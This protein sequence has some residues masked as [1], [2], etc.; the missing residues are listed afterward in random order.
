MGH[1][2]TVASASPPVS[3]LSYLTDFRN[4]ACSLN[5][6][7]LDWE[8]NAQ[9]IIQSI[10]IAK[11]KGAKLR[12]GP[13]L[14]VS[15][16]DCLDH[17][18]EPETFM[19]SWEMLARI[20]DDKD[21]YGCL[22][23]IGA[24]IMHRNLRLNCR[25]LALDGKILLI[26]PKLFL[27]N[28]GNYREMRYF[29]PWPQGRVDDLILPRSMQARQGTTCVPIGDAVLSMADTCIGAET[30]E[31]LFTPDGPHIQMGL[32][33]VEIL[34][35][36]SAS[37][38]ELRKLDRRIALV[39]E[40]TQKSGG[41]YV[42]ANL[43]GCNGER[44]YYDGSSMIFVNGR[45]KAQGGQFTAQDIEV[46]TA[47]VDLEEVRAFR[48]SMSRGMQAVRPGAQCRRIDVTGF[49]MS[50]HEDDYQ[51]AL[52]PTI[53]AKTLSV[54]EEMRGP[55]LW[56]WD[57]L[58]RSSL[59]GFLVPLSGGIDSACTS[60]I[61]FFMCRIL[62]DDIRQGDAQVI[63]DVQR[64]AGAYEKDGWLPQSPQAL[65]HNLLHTIYMGMAKQ[66]S[67]ETRSRAKELARALG[68][69]HV[70]VDIDD[71]Y[72]AH[73]QVF[74]KAT[75]FEPRFKVHGGSGFENNALQN[76]Q[77]RVRMV[78]A[79]YHSQLLPTV[80]QRRGGGNL[81]VLGSANVDESLRGLHAL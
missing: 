67:R 4:R 3:T 36:S 27:C 68:S 62:V 2:T 46:I 57:Y 32:Q 25:V 51:I 40:A 65:M 55:A 64:I 37:H 12:V 77:A 72:E 54:E 45:L 58:R 44:T 70:E 59:A 61:I 35:N 13:E 5:N 23:D 60:V 42:Y 26:R 43:K 14:E 19:F 21:C 81:L 71:I 7:A 80:R 53:D 30:C 52:S 10:L 66:S 31:E 47:T 78:Q 50:L 18:L 34:T 8:N 38:H 63:S 24:P 17:F 1:L 22:L 49:N 20:L 29:Q 41:I 74:F 76:V 6:W 48:C 56:C 39:L 69:Y 9:R 75:N 11:Q 28:D 79:Y 15:G 16:Y 33:G 73:K